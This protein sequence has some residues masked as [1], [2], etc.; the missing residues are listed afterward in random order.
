MCGRYYIGEKTA[1]EIEQELG[2]EDV[3]SWLQYGDVTPATSPL[4]LSARRDG[5]KELLQI[6]NMFW[7]VTGKDDKLIINARAESVLTKPMFAG[8]FE[9]RRC[10][11][12]AEG[13]YEW[14]KEKNKVTFFRK[15]RGPIY[16]AGIYQLSQNRDSFAI[17]TTEANESMIKVH[18]R[19]PLMIEG[20]QVRA[21][22]YD[23]E[24]AKKML[25]AQMPFLD[26]HRD[27]EQLSLF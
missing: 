10:I 7:G 25:M 23:T 20:E 1:Y 2:I 12:P 17:L 14:D 4:V 9:H 3:A 24:E 6:G 22:L 18:D 8:D 13:F 15:D 16:L 21:W 19:M 27:Y 11:L 5:T 26:S